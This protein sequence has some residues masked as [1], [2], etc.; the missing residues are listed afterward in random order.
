MNETNWNP[1]RKVVGGA[2]AVIAMVILQIVF[3]DLD[4]PVGLEGSVAIL[5]AYFVPNSKE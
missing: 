5:A 3:P 1:E 4:I 2:I